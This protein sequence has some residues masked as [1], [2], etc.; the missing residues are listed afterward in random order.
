MIFVRVF[1]NQFAFITFYILLHYL[2][3]FTSPFLA[4][5]VTRSLDPLFPSFQLC[6]LCLTL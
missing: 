6:D 2:L 5:C 1:R 3:F 4:R